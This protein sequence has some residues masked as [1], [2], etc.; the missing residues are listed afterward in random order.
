MVRH[1]LL[2]QLV[3]DILSSKFL[4]NLVLVL[5]AVVT[6]CIVFESGYRNTQ[7]YY[8]GKMAEN[9]TRLRQFS[10]DPRNNNYLANMQLMMKP[11][12]ERFISS[13]YE[14]KLP[15]GFHSQMMP[16][17]L[18]IL[19]QKEDISG[20][21]G[22][23]TLSK[24]E[25]VNKPAFFSTDLTFIVQFLLSFFAIILAFNA[26]TGEKEAG[27][28]R[29]ILSNSVK[30]SDYLIVKYISALITVGLPM[31]FSLILSM[32]LLGISSNVPLSLSMFFELFIFSL[33]SLLYL[34]TFILIGLFCSVFSQSS[35]KSLVLCLLFWIFLV[36]ILPKSPGLFLSLKHF[37]V[38]T[39]EQIEKL[40]ENASQDTINKY[41][42]EMLSARQDEEK[43]QA[44]MQEG[45][46]EMFKVKQDVF[47]YY[48]QRK[49]SAV[50]E[51]RKVNLVSPASLFEYA[52]AS[53]AGTGIAHFQDFW[54]QA[55][56]FG[57]GF[58]D[59]VK[60]ISGEKGTTS[61][62]YINVGSIISKHI[63]FNSVPK[64]E[65]KDIKSGER[66]KNALP[67][68]GLLVLYNLLLFG[69]VFYKFQNYDVR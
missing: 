14:E 69:I 67:Y 57:N 26:T 31:V 2:R 63:D 3:D 66:I 18:K 59:F 60:Q 38:P 33:L 65:E 62:S 28:L 64:F 12:A 41:K 17:E 48:L 25:Y 22:Y 11:R 6:F 34:S 68:I 36:V 51:L 45:L 20:E 46:E 37:D 40:A 42:Q 15:Q 43:L 10:E 35:K 58:I 55:R 44:V 49:V 9:E 21:A 30:R 13:G 47:D 54:M 53:I 1:M 27:T 52:S 50:L 16:F 56:Q 29:L 39:S 7:E 24:R 61:T 19:N 23:E 32:V 5:T 8:S 4:V